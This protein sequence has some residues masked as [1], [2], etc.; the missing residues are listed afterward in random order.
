[1]KDKIEHKFKELLENQELPYDSAAWDSMSKLLD[2]KMPVAKPTT[3]YRWLLGG[4]AITAIAIVSYF[5]VNSSE[6]TNKPVEIN[7]EIKSKNE[8]DTKSTKEEIKNTKLDLKQKEV[9]SNFSA[10]PTVISVQENYQSPTLIEKENN[11][12]VT[13]Q[14]KEQ[15]Q[16]TINEITPA[17]T[18]ENTSSTAGKDIFQNNENSI[19]NHTVV[20]KNNCVGETQVLENK[21]DYKVSVVNQS[22]GEVVASI[23]PKSKISFIA[24]TPGNYVIKTN[25]SV[26][27]SFEVST[28]VKPNL[29]IE[30]T[31][32]YNKGIPTIKA[33]TNVESG[34]TWMVNNKTIN[35]SA[36]E[37][38]ITPFKAGS[39][40]VSVSAHDNGCKTE[41]SQAIQISDDYNLLAVNAFE[42]TSFEPKRQT[43]IP[44]ALTQREVKFTMLIL[45]PRDGGLVYKTSDASLPWNGADMRSGQIV[46]SG[47]DFIWKV[48]LVNPLPGEPSEYKGIISKL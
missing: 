13:A 37:I 5:L 30:T 32:T 47:Q 6:E 23:A 17:K 1:M 28:G 20:C 31:I 25:S 42:P 38:D 43:F 2:Q 7:T 36:S 45:D 18:Q 15:S 14:Q 33:S 44:F 48:Q 12:V 22:S 21:N 26:V 9:N 8:V 16:N 46:N 4:A 35:S 3:L 41:N 27:S 34:L 10:K 11:A 24:K 40:T 39:Y 19:E 29:E